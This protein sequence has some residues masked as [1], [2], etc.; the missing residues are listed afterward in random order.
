MDIANDNRSTHP[1]LKYLTERKWVIVFA[2]T[3]MLITTLPY[4]LGYWVET[5]DPQHAW[6]FS[7]FV[8]GVEDGNSYIAKA[9]TGAFGAW[10][11]RTPYTVIPQNG[12]I[13]FLPFLLL[14]KLV[15][16]PG[17]HEQLVA[18][19]HLFRFFAGI[20][21]ILATYDFINYFINNIKL[22]QFGL[23]IATLGG[24]LGWIL[25]LFGKS[26]L[27]GTLPLEFYSPEAF[28]FLGIYG[29][30]HVAMARALLFWGLLWHFKLARES[31]KVSYKNGL[32]IGF[33]WL[34]VALMQPLTAFIMGMVLGL[35]LVIVIVPKLGSLNMPGSSESTIV[36]SKIRLFLLE[37]LPPLP[38]FI[39]YVISFAG[40]EFMRVWSAQNM[41]TSPHPVHYLLAYGILLPLVIAGIYATIKQKWVEAGVL[42]GWLILAAM[43]AYAPIS[44]QRRLVDGIWVVLVVLM[45]I[46]YQWIEKIRPTLNLRWCLPVMV[47]FT[48]PSAVILVVGGIIAVLKPSEPIFRPNSE[49]AAFQFLGGFVQPNDVV[50]ASYE[51]GNALPAWAPV[52]V[53]I[54]LGPES[55]YLPEFSRQVEIFYDNDSNDAARQA[56]IEKY[57]I[58]YVFWG[59]HEQALGGWDPGQ[60]S[61][62]SQIFSLNGY[63]I[64]EV[65]KP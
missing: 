14:G 61:W 49:V 65:V 51:T 6:R 15:S 27:M 30:P 23:V 8:F 4:F 26:V 43:L 40:D 53:L 55:A 59:P 29:L 38:F 50:L 37:L 33:I 46:G 24:G 9:L 18:L 28:G 52:R 10:L 35:H 21:S 41:I 11:F 32:T 17:M 22:S 45:L 36:G 16:A 34:F 31:E 3:V 5:S 62:L 19:F 64:F 25:L 2:I 56:I 60:V 20:L 42:V 13:A 7:G 48:I 47:C 1:L 63:V 44:I 12:V 58:R 54:G 57:A 39:Y